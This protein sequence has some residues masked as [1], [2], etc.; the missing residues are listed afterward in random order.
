VV[1][2]KSENNNS[3]EE[4]WPGSDATAKSHTVGP[5]HLASAL[6]TGANQVGHGWTVTQGSPYQTNIKFGANGTHEIEGSDN[7]LKF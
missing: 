2:T 6:S 1:D 4:N 3:L 7:W 5:G